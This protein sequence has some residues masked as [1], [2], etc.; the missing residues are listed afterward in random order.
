LEISAEELKVAVTKLANNSSCFTLDAYTAACH[1]TLTQAKK[2]NI[3]VSIAALDAHANLAFFYRDP[4]SLLVS[5]EF[6]Q[7]KAYSAYAMQTNTVEL[8]ALTQPGAPLYQLESMTANS[9]VTF[10]GGV[11]LRNMFDQLI[12]A[13]GVSGA[14]DP[15]DDH[16]LAQFFVEKLQTTS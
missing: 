5:L 11:V 7:K 9:I 6:A 4:N 10:G 3:A 2:Q 12:G 16:L 13:I 8:G 1:A 15:H 14:L